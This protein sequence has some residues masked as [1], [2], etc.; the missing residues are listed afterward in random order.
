MLATGLLV[1]VVN[2]VVYV[3]GRLPHPFIITLAMLSIARGLALWLSGGQP[4]RGMPEVVNA[5]GGGSIGLVPVSAV[6]VLGH[7]RPRASS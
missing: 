4:I 7:R 2:G 5:I 3:K 6:L 1:G